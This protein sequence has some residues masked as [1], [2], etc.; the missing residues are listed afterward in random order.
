MNYN[1]FTLENYHILI[2]K[3]ININN[4]ALTMAKLS[5]EPVLRW[6]T[7]LLDKFDGNM[8]KSREFCLE[9]LDTYEEIYQS[10][11]TTEEA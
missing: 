7:N 6:K 10:T 2:E 8:Q 11:K 9:I 1:Q 5:G 3:S 4:L